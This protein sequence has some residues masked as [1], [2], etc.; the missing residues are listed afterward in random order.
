MMSTQTD[1]EAQIIANSI[2][3]AA[4]IKPPADSHQ[5]SFQAD[6]KGSCAQQQIDQASDKQAEILANS[7]LASFNAMKTSSTG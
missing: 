3:A 4:G 7:I 6:L 2:L 1:R 5:D